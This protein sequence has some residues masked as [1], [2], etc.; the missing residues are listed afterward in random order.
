LGEAQYS[1]RKIRVTV[2]YTFLSRGRFI[3]FNKPANIS[4]DK[5]AVVND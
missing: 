2:F 1:G 3:S 4:D 5:Q